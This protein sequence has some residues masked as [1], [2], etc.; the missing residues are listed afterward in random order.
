MS[1]QGKRMVKENLIAQIGQGGGGT[2]YTAGSGIDITED[3]ISVD[4]TVALKSD[5]ADYALKEQVVV[6]KYVEFTGLPS[7][8]DSVAEWA[9]HVPVLKTNAFTDADTFGHPVI[10]LD[11]GAV[12]A[13]KSFFVKGFFCLRNTSL[14]TTI[15]YHTA[16]SAITDSTSSATFNEFE[17]FRSGNDDY[18]FLG[19]RCKG[20]GVIG[21]LTVYYVTR[22]FY[23]N[24]TVTAAGLG[25]N[26]L[27]IRINNPKVNV[28]LPTTTPN[29]EGTYR[30]T[31]TVDSNG[32]V[33]AM[34]WVADSQ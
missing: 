22:A 4:N 26:T 32:Q 33:S 10:E 27:M 34:A 14:N 16:G 9:L 23:Q 7:E 8:Y 28:T 30:L 5:L 6:H 21:D 20:T 1:N 15:Y 31:C 24:Q 25:M 2:E 19:A 18:T 29:T 12:Q 11:A 13:N 17:A 3:V